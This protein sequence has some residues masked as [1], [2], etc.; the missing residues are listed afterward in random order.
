MRY[1]I[2]QT[3]RFSIKAFLLT[4]LL[5]N[6]N[7]NLHINQIIMPIDVLIIKIKFY[8]SVLKN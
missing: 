6:F 3:F 1:L 8:C 7:I 5:C 4:S 2:I